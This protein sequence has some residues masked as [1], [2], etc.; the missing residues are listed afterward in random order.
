MMDSCWKTA[1]VTKGDPRVRICEERQL[2]DVLH[3][4]TVGD[5]L[6]LALREFLA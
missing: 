3:C 4:H 5:P 2:G 6:S 1:D